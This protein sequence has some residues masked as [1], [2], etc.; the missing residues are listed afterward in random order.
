VKAYDD[1][2]IFAKILKGEIPCNKVYENDHVLA[3]MDIMP[4]GDGHALVIPK[5]GSRNI[6]DVLP[7]D[8]AE[9]AKG[10]QLVARAA[11]RAFSADGLTIQQF[12][13]SAGGQVV[14]HLH[15]HIIPRWEGVPLKPHTGIVEKPEIL[16]AHAEKLRRAIEQEHAL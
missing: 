2:N 4:R 3:F 6:L 7:E 1:S 15:V 9:V 11:M 10:V 13:E 5:K 8:L 14:F 16:A 12:N